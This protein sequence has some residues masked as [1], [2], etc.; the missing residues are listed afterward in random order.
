MIKK[1]ISF[2]T[3][4]L[5]VGCVTTQPQRISSTE[6]GKPEATIKA[7]VQDIKNEIINDM[8]NYKYG[9][10]TDTPFSLSFSRPAE[11]NENFMAYFKSGNAYS[12]NERLTVY[13][14]VVRGDSVRV[15]ALPQ[16]RSRMVGGQVNTSD[17][18]GN[19]NIYNE[20]QKQL[21]DVKTKLE[22]KK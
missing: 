5:L 17:V 4:I 22:A 9:I 13:N 15:I 7:T 2:A 8:L 19:S 10:E 20:Y 1:L 11:G 12:T 21:N 6:S 3:V 16:I 14:F 18:S